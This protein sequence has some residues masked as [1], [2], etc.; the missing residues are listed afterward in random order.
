[1]PVLVQIPV[2]TVLR[3]EFVAIFYMVDV[4][5]LP[6]I[7]IVLQQR[8]KHPLQVVV[9]R[10]QVRIDHPLPPHKYA[11]NVPVLAVEYQHLAQ[12]CLLLYH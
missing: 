12:S 7:V 11:P 10:P 3:G 1:M 5:P 8:F 2:E 9:P 6:Q 4:L